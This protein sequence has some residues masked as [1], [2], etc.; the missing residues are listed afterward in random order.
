MTDFI[1]KFAEHLKNKEASQKTIVNYLADIRHFAKW[2][3]ETN[4]QEL[5]LKEI[6]PTDIREYKSYL[7]TNERRQPATINRRLATLR[8]LCAWAKREGLIG[9]NPTEDIK[10]IERVKMAPRA[11]EKKEVDRLTRYAYKNGNKR[12]FAIIQVLKNTGIRVGELSN[13]R[14]DDVEIFERKGH[15]VV[16]SGKGGKYRI[17]PLNLDARKA[18]TEYL[19]VRPE[20]EDNHLFIGQRDHGLKPSAIYDIVANYARGAGLQDVSPHILRHTFGKHALDAGEN[21][22]TVATL[23]GHARLDTTA[24]YTQPSQQDLEKA[25]EKLAVGEK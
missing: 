3:E 25:V 17:V 12:N 10:G 11:L 19:K 9:D 21:L 22:V 5:A 1:D 2:F 13:L 23:M 7:L 20:V 4:G 14:Q 8:R 24:I 6:T 18:I 15:I 16:R